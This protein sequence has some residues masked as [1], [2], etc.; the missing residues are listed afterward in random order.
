[1]AG[2]RLGTKT[3]DICRELRARTRGRALSIFNPSYDTHVVNVP[4]A[5][6]LTSDDLKT[7]IA[8]AIVGFGRTSRLKCIKR[9]MS[10]VSK[11]HGILQDVFM[12]RMYIVQSY[13]QLLNHYFPTITP[14]TENDVKD[15]CIQAQPW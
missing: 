15:S 7:M 4:D 13:L 6:D 12:E 10:T 1:M 9:H 14:L 8:N 3:S 11:P 2:T 5:S